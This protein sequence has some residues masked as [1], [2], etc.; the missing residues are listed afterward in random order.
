VKPLLVGHQYE[1]IS[2]PRPRGEEVA[3]VFKSAEDR[4]AFRKEA[5]ERENPRYLDRATNEAKPLYWN[6]PETKEEK[7]KKFV[8]R[9]MGKWLPT[10]FPELAFEAGQRTGRIYANTL[11]LFTV[12]LDRDGEVVLRFKD[13][14]VD[15]LKVDKTVIESHLTRI[16]AE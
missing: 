4:N 13:K 6:L 12:I 10:A 14:S 2:A 5:I 15:T 9:R 7:R 16:L 8:V 1:R 3:V 11:H